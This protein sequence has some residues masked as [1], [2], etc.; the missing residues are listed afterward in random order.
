MLKDF[1]N[2]SLRK[3]IYYLRNTNFTALMQIVER[4]LIAPYLSLRIPTSPQRVCLIISGCPGDSFRYRCEHQAAQ[5][6]SLG[7]TNDICYASQIR[8]SAVVDRYQWFWLHRVAY[9][10]S[11]EALIE[12]AQRS[13][14]PVVFDT[15]DLVFD[16]KVISYMRAIESMSKREVDQVYARARGYYKTLSRCNFATVSTEYLR[17]A[18]VNLFP[19]VRGFVTP[20]MLSDAQL[21]LAAQALKS[22]DL[23]N[24]IDKR[25]VT[26]GYFSG[27]RTHNA[28]FNECAS[29][30]I[31]ILEAHPN[32][33]LLLVGYLD[34]GR[35]FTGFGRRVT[36]HRFVPWQ[37]L[38]R[39]LSKVDINL[40]PLEIDNP[41]TTCKSD[42][43][44]IEAAIMGIPTVASAVGSFE[45]SINHGEN[46]FLCR[47]E[48]DWFNCLSRLVEDFALRHRM[49]KLAKELVRDARTIDRGAQHLSKTLLGSIKKYERS[50]SDVG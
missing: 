27:T 31:R 30:L 17:E 49:G 44:Y 39:L 22:E 10:E 34:V 7:L 3:L 21:D 47:T 41:F 12:A 11:I 15:D 26:I 50:I 33:R 23:G 18:V 19:D 4:K 14:K 25:S 36:Q 40:A 43:K 37:R 28:D 45:K 46:G 13:S 48:E 35:E 6:E 2:D 38:S 5:L 32:V 24:P 1:K 42:L 9:S 29:A 16:E 8:D 20:N